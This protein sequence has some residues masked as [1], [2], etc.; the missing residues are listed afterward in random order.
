MVRPEF[1]AGRRP[2]KAVVAAH[3]GMCTGCNMMLPPQLYNELQ[4]D[5]K[6]LQCTTCQRILFYESEEDRARNN[7]G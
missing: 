5:L 3:Q 2:G 1:I 4:L 6:I 7:A